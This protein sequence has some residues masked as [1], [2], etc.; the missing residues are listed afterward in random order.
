MKTLRIPLVGSIVQRDPGPAQNFSTDQFFDNCAPISESNP[1]T[2][3]LS[4]WLAKRTGFAA[5]VQSVTTNA[6][7]S[8]GAVVWTGNAAALATAPV[9]A[10]YVRSASSVAFFNGTIQV[11]S[12]VPSTNSCAYM[13][14]TTISGTSHLTASLKDT[15]TSTIRLYFFP[16][17]GAWTAVTSAHLTTSTVPVCAEHAHMDGY[18]FAMRQDGRIYNSDLNTVSSWAAASFLT[19]NSFADKGVGV[20][21]Y[22][23]LIV[24]FGDYS[25]EFFYNAGNAAG[26]V[27]SRVANADLRIGCVRRSNTNGRVFMPVG[28]TVYW[29][30]LNPESGRKGIY[31]LKGFGAEKISTNTVDNLLESSYF[32]VGAFQMLGMAHLMIAEAITGAALCYCIDRNFWWRFVPGG[33]LPISIVIGGLSNAPTQSILLSPLSAATYVFQTIGSSYQDATSTFSLTV[34][35]DN[36][37]LGTERKKYW[38]KLR[39]TYDRQSSTSPITIKSS[40]DDFATF[41]TLGSIDTVSSN[42]QNWISRLGASRRRSWQFTHSAN[43]PC[44]IS[45]VEID[46][47]VGNP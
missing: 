44:R 35:T 17:G 29:I 47:D 11:G 4:V 39:I 5:S 21:R 24:G 10:S 3:K 1:I 43:T 27:L 19:A 9:I 6:L 42:A 13:D 2:G 15:A 45:A 34:Q 30:G 26:S 18:Q 12:D 38:R 7:G 20:C 25:T 41:S 14:E 22:K 33:G 40:D 31:R 37:D 16:E 8:Y 32:V 28:D 36:M 46:Y 23:N